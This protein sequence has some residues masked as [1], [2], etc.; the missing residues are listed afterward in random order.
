MTI[1]IPELE[2]AT[3]PAIRRWF[4]TVT[5]YMGGEGWHADDDPSDIIDRRTGKPF[6]NEKELEIVYRAMKQIRPASKDWHDPDLLYD[7]AYGGP[8]K[9]ERAY[10]G[11]HLDVS[12]IAG[13]MGHTFIPGREHPNLLVEEMNQYALLEFPDR[14]GP[15]SEQRR[16]I[17]REVE[18]SS[19]MGWPLDPEDIVVLED[20]IL[21]FG[22]I[23]DLEDRIVAFAEGERAVPV[24]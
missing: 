22:S 5:D 23:Y 4:E 11:F 13:R 17:L 18:S 7:L 10:P 24:P 21:E 6:F 14:S 1:R 8:F 16:F 15:V 20:E 3:Y 19:V 2:D 12:T 9:V